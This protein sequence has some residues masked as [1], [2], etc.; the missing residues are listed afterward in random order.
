MGSRTRLVPVKISPLQYIGPKFS[1]CLQRERPALNS[2]FVI[3]T[4]R[5]IITNKTD[6]F[7]ARRYYHQTHILRVILPKN[8]IQIFYGHW[9]VSLDPFFD[10]LNYRCPGK[11]Y[12]QKCTFLIS[13]ISVFWPNYCQY[14]SSNFE[15]K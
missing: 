11:G 13:M 10:G 2:K 14:S 8:I 4:V 9:S 12:S 3:P 15:W 5:L 6:L 1:V 7:F